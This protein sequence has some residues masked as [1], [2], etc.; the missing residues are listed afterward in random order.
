[1]ETQQPG[2]AAT[3]DRPPLA[4]VTFVGVGAIG[5]PMARRLAAAGFLVTA[6]DPSPRTRAEAEAAGLGTA[7]DISSVTLGDVVV[8]MVA[9]GGQLLDAVAAATARGP[10]TGQ[11][12]VIGSTVGPQDGRRAAALLGEAGAQVVDAPVLG[13][14]PGAE[15]GRAGQGRAGC[16]SSPREVRKHSTGSATYSAPWARSP[17]SATGPAMDR[18]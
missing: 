6:V 2:P 15:Q 17:R 10:L 16:A 14:V 1:M 11:T 12:W 8:V 3:T 7:P 13:G 5:L 4:T 18:R 9:T